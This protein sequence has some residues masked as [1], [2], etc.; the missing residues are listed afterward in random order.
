[1]I[2]NR[3]RAIAVFSAISLFAVSAAQAAQIALS[4]NYANSGNLATQLNPT[5]A[6]GI[7]GFTNWNN[8]FDQRGAPGNTQ[9]RT[10]G[11]LKLSTGAFAPNAKIDSWTPGDGNSW[12]DSPPAVVSSTPGDAK[13]W[14]LGSRDYNPSTNGQ[15]IQLSGLAASFPNGFSI[16]TYQDYL[17]G[18]VTS[19]EIRVDNLGNGVGIDYTGTFNLVNTLGFNNDFLAN[20]HSTTI[21]GI[22]AGTDQIAITFKPLTGAA[23]SQATLL[24][25]QIV[26]IVADPIPVPE[27]TSIALWSLLG[28]VGLAF[29]ARGFRNR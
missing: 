1:M 24:G 21:A 12:N 19:G 25:F 18:P 8:L 13:L 22:A 29:G 11:Q 26:G 14:A 20:G 27:P 6:A 9:F 5:D 3:A 4:L 15:R 7:S 16:V 2:L 23:F 28:I 17:S 10:A